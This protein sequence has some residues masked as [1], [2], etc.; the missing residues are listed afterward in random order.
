MQRYARPGHARR[1]LDTIHVIFTFYHTDL[2]RH[3]IVAFESLSAGTGETIH[4]ANRPGHDI[5]DGSEQT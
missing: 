1:V 4:L 2:P 3:P 5:L